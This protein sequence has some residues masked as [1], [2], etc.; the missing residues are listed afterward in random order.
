[1]RAKGLFAGVALEGAVIRLDDDANRSVYGE[2]SVAADLAGRTVSATAGNV[3]GSFLAALERYIP[4][5]D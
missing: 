1:M 2:T 5:H 4:A 3:V